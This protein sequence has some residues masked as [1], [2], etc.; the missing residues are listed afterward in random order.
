[1]P[2]TNER[3]S[4]AVVIEPLTVRISTAVQL[5]GIS[6]SRLYE[7]IQSGDL[8]T[9]KVGRSTLIPYKSLKALTGA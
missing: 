3:Q 1:M 2:S 4:H 9:I 7:L 6:R 5:T 8:T